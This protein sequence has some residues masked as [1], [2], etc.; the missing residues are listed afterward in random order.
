M[1]YNNCALGF[2]IGLGCGVGI[3]LLLAPKS[4]NETRSLIGNKAQEET[5]RLKLQA[6]RLRDSAT[7]LI[8]KVRHDV[9]RHKEGLHH[10]IEAGTNGHRESAA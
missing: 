6:A 5:D 9:T 4:G 7:E 3:A 10:A 2:M 8:E 1:N